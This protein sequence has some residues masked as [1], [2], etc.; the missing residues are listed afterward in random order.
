MK[1]NGDLTNNPRVATQVTSS[2]GPHER[3]VTTDVLEQAYVNL[4]GNEGSVIDVGGGVLSSNMGL[5]KEC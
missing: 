1:P 4:G 3:G 5:D 2:D